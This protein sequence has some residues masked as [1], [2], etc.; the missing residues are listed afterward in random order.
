[1]QPNFCNFPW[2][3]LIFAGGPGLAGPG[4]HPL[5]RIR[6]LSRP[7]KVFD[8]AGSSPSATPGWVSTV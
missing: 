3:I 4:G 8:G 5:S 2:K 1:M 6:Q 7:W